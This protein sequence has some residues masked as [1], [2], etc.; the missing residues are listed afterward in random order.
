[1]TAQIRELLIYDQQTYGMTC[2]PFDQ[3]IIKN[4][5]ELRL[6]W[7]NTALWRGYMGEWEITN[8]KLYL[9]KISG[10]GQIRNSEN[11]RLGRLELR[12]KLKEGIITPQDNGHLLMQLKEDCMEDIELSLK[13]LF[14]SEEKVFANW[15]SG[16]IVCP[17]GEMIEYIHMGYESVFEYEYDFEIIDGELTNITTKTNITNINTKYNKTNI[18]LFQRIINFLNSKP[19]KQNILGIYKLFRKRRNK[20]S[21]ETNLKD[22]T[23][24]IKANTWNLKEEEE[25]EGTDHDELPNHKGEFGFS[26]D[27]PILLIS[28]SESRKYL[29]KLIYIKPG[30][31]HY[32][33]ERTGSMKSS[34]VSTPIDEY[35]LLD[36]NFNIVKTIYIWPYNRINS[37]KVPEGFSLMDY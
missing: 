24:E 28:V 27:N 3:Y 7:P 15:F 34:I 31:S 2:E 30:S 17:Y 26:I 6:H 23:L 8:N 32:T 13:T 18:N 25:E 12:K 22:F 1:M 4:K 14:N 10:F 36:T 35:N 20:K 11:F 33:W 16:T 5:L 21:N 29:D 9:T 19:I 37:K